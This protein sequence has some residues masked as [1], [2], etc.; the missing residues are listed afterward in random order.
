MNA[1]GA[2]A[3]TDVKQFLLF[4]AEHTRLH[5]LFHVA[6]MTGMRRGE[7]LG[8]R[9]E[10]VNF[11]RSEL[12]VRRAIVS[13]RNKVTLSAPKT[14]KGKRVDLVGRG[15]SLVLR[16][17]LA[18]QDDEKS[19]VG[20]I[21]ED[22]GLVFADFDGKILHPDRLSQHFRRQV[23]THALPKI[24]F[25][26]LR[27]THATLALKAG[28][29]PKIVS[30]TAWSCEC[31]ADARPV[32]A[33]DSVTAGGCCDADRRS[34]RRVL[35]TFAVR[36]RST[37]M[38]A[39]SLSA[40]A[41]FTAGSRRIPNPTKQ[42]PSSQFGAHRGSLPT[43]EVVFPQYFSQAV[44]PLWG[45]PD[46]HFGDASATPTE[47]CSS[48]LF[49]SPDAKVV[50]GFDRQTRREGHILSLVPRIGA[51]AISPPIG[52]AWLAVDAVSAGAGRRAPSWRGE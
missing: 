35:T 22:Q 10:D 52:R 19:A 7:L 15:H 37:P 46:R 25:H 12:A 21:Y 17:H 29:H 39:P 49:T 27:H 2:W 34:P 36:L 40:G 9:W 51:S 13:V 31:D 23:D 6:L 4:T 14:A 38:R 45:I 43:P 24:S 11:D 18:R 48:V 32:L 50:P 44:D 47:Y 33:C 42:G 8:L 1:S 5:A 16:A 28:V 20:S 30:E 41:A 26:D 3:L